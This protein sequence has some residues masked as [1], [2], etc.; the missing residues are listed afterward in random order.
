ML[1]E[2]LKYD[3]QMKVAEFSIKVMHIP[4]SGVFGAFGP[5]ISVRTQPGQH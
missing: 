2:V 5:A 3:I 4:S 1:D